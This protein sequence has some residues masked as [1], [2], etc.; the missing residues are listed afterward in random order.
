MRLETSASVLPFVC[1]N[2]TRNLAGLVLAGI[3]LFGELRKYLRRILSAFLLNTISTVNL[4]NFNQT[5][6]TRD[7]AA[8]VEIDRIHLKGHKQ[9]V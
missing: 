9:C 5:D 7:Q 3:D 4:W 8:K 1:Y 2:A 6:I